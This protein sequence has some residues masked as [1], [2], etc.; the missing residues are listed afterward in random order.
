MKIKSIME[1]AGI[2]AKNHSA[3]LKVN[4]D[5]YHTHS[6]LRGCLS[7]EQESIDI[8]TLYELLKIMNNKLSF[9]AKITSVEHENIKEIQDE[10]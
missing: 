5:E 3:K 2:I 1:Q 7:G 8:C 10:S 9:I 6:V 4:C